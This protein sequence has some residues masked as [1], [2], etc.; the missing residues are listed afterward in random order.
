MVEHKGG[1]A[2]TDGDTGGSMETKNQVLSEDVKIVDIG[3]LLI[4][5]NYS[6]RDISRHTSTV[7]D[8][9]DPE[10]MA[11][12]A[13]LIGDFGELI[14]QKDNKANPRDS[15]L[16]LSQDSFHCNKFNRNDHISNK[17]EHPNYDNKKP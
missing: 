10:V 11:E 5:L 13:D 4:Y 7:R 6:K 2:Y 16:K 1:V 9:A 8:L 12:S 17:S 15:E 3:S 14:F